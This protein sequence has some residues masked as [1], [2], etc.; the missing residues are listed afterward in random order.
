MKLWFTAQEIGDLAL[1]GL[2][3]TKR[4]VNVF[5]AVSGWAGRPGLS[6]PHRGPGGGVEYHL[7][8]L[9]PDARRAYVE[10]LMPDAVPEAVAE[11]AEAEPAAAHLRDDAAEARDARLA[12]LAAADRIFASAKLPRLNADLLAVADFTAGRLSLPAWVHTAVPKLTLR[13]LQRWR[14]A[15]RDGRTAALG[16]DRGASRRGLGVLD[17]AEDGQVRVYGLALIARQPHLSADHV[18]EMLC[19]RFGE[20]LTVIKAGGVVKTVPMPPIRTVQDAL[21]RW[22]TTE[23]VALAAITNPDAYKSRY[24]L[25]GNNAAGYVSRLNEVW[26]IDA[27][28]MDALCVDG[29]HSVYLALDIWS[30]RVV[31]YVSKT[32]RA[33]A[34]GLLLRRAILAWGVPERIKTDNGSDFTAKASQ[35]L[36]ASLGIAHELSPAFTPEDKGHVERAIGTFQRDLGPILPGFVG[37]SVADRKVIEARRAFSARIN[38]HDDAKAFC[39]EL[40]GHDLQEYCD[41]WAENR[42]Q[43]RKHAGLRERADLAIRTPFGAAAAFTGAI[44]RIEDVRALDLLLAPVAGKDGI[45]TVGKQGIRIER[46]FYLAPQVMPDTQVFVR[47]DPSDLGRAYLFALD[48]GEYLVEAIC[49]EILGVDPVEAVALAKD[50]RKALIDSRT[51]AIRR[52]AKAIRPRD[53]ADTI[54]GRAAAASSK[55][56]AFPRP[57][58]VHTTPEIEAAGH[59]ARRTNPR[60]ARFGADSAA[61]LAQIEAEIVAPAALP[62]PKVTELRPVDP[63]LER[64]RRAL[65]IQRRLKAGAEVA[66]Q[67]AFW[68]GSYAE[69]H[70]YKAMAGFVED[71]GEEALG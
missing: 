61:M 52:E 5:A 26:Q 2:P 37:H 24:K 55:V 9:P 36:L 17:T 16:V 40:S 10:R 64:F 11:A 33:E 69:G 50:A 60:P 53:F 58:A 13:T 54:L 21:R 46:S 65:D 19:A 57:S 23:K 4:N 34:V 8:L 43:H 30:R 28:P 7:D 31:V 32:P 15:A 68:L 44:Q 14:A 56:V 63:K 45:R 25:A 71:F 41:A 27:S 3:A 51:A 18:R 49:P 22:K 59:A 20:S 38:D 67:E 42:Y 12:I 70:E 62:R 29:R 48:G 1:P 66:A 6:R 35:R 39:V 47:M